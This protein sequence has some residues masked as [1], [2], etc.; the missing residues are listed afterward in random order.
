MRETTHDTV[1]HAAF[2]AVWVLGVCLGVAF[3]ATVLYLVWQ[4]VA[5]V[6]G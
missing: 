6:T 3:W 1:I 5:H 2:V 4:L